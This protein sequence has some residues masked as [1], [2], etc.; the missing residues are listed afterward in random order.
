MDY[1]RLGDSGIEVSPLC[2]GT[3]N[4]GDRTDA[5]TARAIVAAAR[6]AG[7]NFIDTADV[8]V[9][10]ESERIT[11]AAVRLTRQLR[12]NPVKTPGDIE[13]QQHGKHCEQALRATVTASPCR[14]ASQCHAGVKRK[15]CVERHQ[16]IHITAEIGAR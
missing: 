13:C 2:L 3:M 12:I 6:D 16:A 5:T 1:Q 8:Y 15:A 11:G 4:F 10:G 14:H 7:V 9:K